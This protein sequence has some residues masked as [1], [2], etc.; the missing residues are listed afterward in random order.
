MEVK[1]S[2]PVGTWIGANEIP[3]LKTPG[4]C[5][6]VAPRRPQPADACLLTP[7]LC[8]LFLRRKQHPD[9]IIITGS[10]SKIQWS[11]TNRV[12]NRNVCAGPAGTFENSPAFQRREQFGIV[13]V[14]EGRLKRHQIEYD[15]RYLWK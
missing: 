14:P 5:R 6:R 3:A 15:E 4:Y 2:R 1:F 10:I 7:F 12:G 9:N 11:L 8:P 13:K